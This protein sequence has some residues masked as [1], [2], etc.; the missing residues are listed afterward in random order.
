MYFQVNKHL[1][2]QL[3]PQYKI[4]PKS[5]IWYFLIS[6][7]VKQGVENNEWVQVYINL[8]GIYEYSSGYFVRCFCLNILYNNIIYFLKNYF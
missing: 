3:L 6:I 1:E 7:K 5:I 4:L 2:K 8:R